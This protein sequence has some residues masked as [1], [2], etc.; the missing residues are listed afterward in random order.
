MNAEQSPEPTAVGA[1]QSYHHHPDHVHFVQ[2]RCMPEVTD[3]LEL[4]YEPL[5]AA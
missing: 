4:D 5:S 1:Y 3:L 2:T